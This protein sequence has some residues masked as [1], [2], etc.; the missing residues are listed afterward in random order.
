[1]MA[2]VPLALSKAMLAGLAAAMFVAFFPLLA[3]DAYIVA[4]YVEQLH[5]GHG[6]VFNQSER[7][8]ALTSPLQLLLMVGL[9]YLF[10][11]IVTAYRIL[12]AAAAIC[13]I[14]LIA[15]RSLRSDSDA[16]AFL[17]FTLTSPFVVFW[18]VGGLETPLLLA[19]NLAITYLAL[20]AAGGRRASLLIILCAIAILTRYDASLFVAPVAVISLLRN[21]AH[22]SAWIAAFIGCTL[23]LSWAAFCVSYYG[24]LLPTSFYVKAGAVPAI[25]ELARGAVYLVSFSV[26][27]LVWLLLSPRTF[28]PRPPA[29]ATRAA[30][31]LGLGLELLYCL[32]AGTKHMMYAYRLFVP[33]FPVIVLL[34]LRASP[35]RSSP[36]VA[37][38]IAIVAGGNAALALTTYYYSENPNLSLLIWQQSLEN[39]MFEF[40]TIGA[41]HT[42]RF[43]A[44]VRSDGVAI[45]NDW[46]RRGIDRPPRLLVSTGGALPYRLIS[47]YTMEKL[48]SFRHTCKPDLLPMADYEQVIFTQPAERAVAAE[49]EK[50]KAIIIAHHELTVDG[51]QKYP[52]NLSIEIW[53]VGAKSPVILPAFTRGPCATLTDRIMRRD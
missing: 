35:N 45:E 21:R 32:W 43:L 24:D 2:R 48:V 15:R 31:Y 19:L 46:K 44:A 25:E 1:M 16:L 50:Q 40:S 30:L 33:Y 7:I 34:L 10:V 52:A 12:A 47:A 11:D 13:V 53:Y 8:N 27:S 6:L 17:A 49:R 38:I 29:D 37:W 18:M 9:R 42:H 23:V 20:K 26:L 14:V 5:L 4:R 28:A 22:K 51:V 36:V 3:D 39:E 41:R